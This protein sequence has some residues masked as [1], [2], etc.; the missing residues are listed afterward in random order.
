M[1]TD[2]KEAIIKLL[3][4]ARKKAEKSSSIEEKRNIYIK[5][6]TNNLDFL[7]VDETIKPNSEEIEQLITD[8]KSKLNQKMRWNNEIN[9]SIRIT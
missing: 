4:S 1:R 2:T 8:T 3:D 5:F 7:D 6:L 9:R